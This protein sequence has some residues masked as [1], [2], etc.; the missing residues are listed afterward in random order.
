MRHDVVDLNSD[1][2]G[3][4]KPFLNVASS[5]PLTMQLSERHCFHLAVYARFTAND[6]LFLL[7]R[8][9]P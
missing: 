8:S 6:L 1:D 9:N 3:A 5:D 2:Y 7:L 4:E